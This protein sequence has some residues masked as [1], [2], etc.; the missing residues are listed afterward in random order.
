[1]DLLRLEVPLDPREGERKMNG[2]PV[3]LFFPL[4]LL[5]AGTM[6][7]SGCQDDSLAPWPRSPLEDAGYDETPAP[8]PLRLKA[9]A[10]DA[11]HEAWHQPDYGGT[12]TTRFTDPAHT[13]VSSLHDWGDSTMWTGTY[14]ASQAFRY[15]V[16]RAPQARTNALRMVDAL[17]G[18]LHVTETPGYIA[19][20]RGSQ[21]GPIYQGD[22]W[23]HAQNSCFHVEEGDFA[24]DFWWGSTSRDQY[25]G[26][27]FGMTMAYDLVDDE[28]MR[29]KI[30]GDVL[31]VVH[32]LLDNGW[33][34]MAQDGNPSGTAPE[35]L[36]S[37]R[38]AFS[39]MSNHITGDERIRTELDRLLADSNRIAVEISDFNF[40]N[41][42]AQYYG[43][44]LGHTNWYNTLRIGR[45]YFDEDDHGWM[46]G[47]FNKAQHTFTRLSHNAWFNSIYM[48]QGGWEPGSEGD[49][50]LEQLFQDLGDF[51]DAPNVRY[52][53]PDRDPATFTVDPESQALHDLFEQY[54]IL[55]EIMGDVN[56][57]ALQGFPVPMQCSTDFLWQRNPFRIQECGSD[58]PRTV[59]PGVDYLVAYWVSAY[60]RLLTKE[61]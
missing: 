46:V 35:V 53:L 7:A 18:H 37:M 40:M 9:E 38:L 13:A 33:V 47:H 49:P 30:R 4:A 2:N 23:C 19:R 16:T 5:I 42:Y 52:Y 41:R 27:F 58:D 36:H 54:P 57:Q 51:R 29:R 34:I 43:N 31:E 17:S 39:T 26:W 32:T 10:Y 60:H 3:P 11:W 45:T 24:G 12:V 14:L 59:N 8:G 21:N 22:E 56:V 6:I 61:Q 1:M 25:I 20:Y 28:P 50:Y 44:N 55:R 15:Y 48:S